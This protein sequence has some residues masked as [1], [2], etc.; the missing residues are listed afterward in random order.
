MKVALE[1]LK[2][3]S[4]EWFSA[5]VMLSWGITFALPGNLMSQPAYIGFNRYGTTD[6]FWALLFGGMGISGLIALYINGRWPR[7]PLIRRVRAMFG[8]VMWAQVS[9]LFFDAAVKN[10]TPIG[11][12]PAVYALLAIFEIVSINR[13]A[14]D[15]RYHHG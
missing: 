2:D 14:Y 4:L 5:C 13:A 10:G 3:R 7:S 15:A 6:A 12:G 9:Y 11:T 8:L 1:S